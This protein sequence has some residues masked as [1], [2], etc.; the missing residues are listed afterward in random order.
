[1]QGHVDG[2]A[3]SF[4]LERR[5]PA[6]FEVRKTAH[7]RTAKMQNRRSRSSTRPTLG[8]LPKGSI[9]IDGISL[10]V[11]PCEA[12]LR[13]SPSFPILRAS[14]NLA[15]LRVGDAVNLETDVLAKY[16]ERLLD[17]RRTP[18]FRG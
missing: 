13:A 16:V 14:T 5:A 15:G 2:V 4:V 10:T 6:I 8:Y 12:V 11:P 7:R 17:A 3:E 9:A 1:M 18:R